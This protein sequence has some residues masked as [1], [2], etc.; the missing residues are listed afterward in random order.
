[1][2]SEILVMVFSSET[3]QMHLH[4]ACRGGEQKMTN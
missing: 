4:L 2:R 3:S 1:M